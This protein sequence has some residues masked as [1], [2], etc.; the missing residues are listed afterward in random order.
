MREDGPGAVDLAKFLLHRGILNGHLLRI[1]VGQQFDGLLVDLPGAGH[2]VE[3]L[4]LADVEHIHVEALGLFHSLNGTVVDGHGV[5][6]KPVLLLQFGIL[7]EELGRCVRGAVLEGLFKEVS[8]ALELI[9]GIAL[10]EAVQVLVPEGFDVGPPKG[11][12]T[13]LED[14]EGLLEVLVL[15]KKGSVVQDDLGRR[16]AELQHTVVGSPGRVHRAQTLLQV[17]VEGPYAH[18]LVQP[19]LDGDLGLGA[20]AL[21]LKGA[22]PDHGRWRLGRRP[23]HDLECRLVAFG[24]AIGVVFGRAGLGD[25]ELHLSPTTP[26]LGEV[27]NGLVSNFNSLL[28]DR[29]RARHVSMVLVELGKGEPEGVRLARRLAWHHGLNSLGVADDHVPKVLSILV[30][31]DPLVPLGNIV[32]VLAKED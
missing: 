8:S 15:L 6:H 29:T 32:G 10:D 24:G 7:E 23:L 12:D 1:H 31:L 25:S 17:E 19:L 11:G 5:A 27:I 14:R 16:D 18:R 13:L 2:T 28:E 3:G 26:D 4:R 30:Q 21:G 9:A 20:P 22:L